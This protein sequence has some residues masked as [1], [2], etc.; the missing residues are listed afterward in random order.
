ML[1]FPVFFF[2]LQLERLYMPHEKSRCRKLP[3]TYVFRNAYRRLPFLGIGLRMHH[4]RPRAD[5][6]N[7]HEEAR[8]PSFLMARNENTALLA[9]F[10]KTMDIAL[11]D[12]LPLFQDG[13]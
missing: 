6:T 12:F 5:C 8:N 9:L 7:S 13:M 3:A 11:E 10:R 4:V 1:S 2:F